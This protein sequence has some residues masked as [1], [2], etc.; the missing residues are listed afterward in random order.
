ML[1]LAHLCDKCGKTAQN[2]WIH[3]RTGYDVLLCDHHSR[4]CATKL[5]EQGFLAPLTEPARP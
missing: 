4:Q 1:D 2:R 5:L 3:G